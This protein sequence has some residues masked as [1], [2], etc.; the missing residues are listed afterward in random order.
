VAAAQ[1]A[2]A[3]AVRP[4]GTWIGTWAAAPQSFLPGNLE[5]FRRQTLRLIVHASVGGTTLRIKLSNAFGD[6]P[7]LIGGAHV[8]RRAADADI[9]AATDRPL[10]FGGRST[11]IVPAGSVVSSDP[12]ALDLHA[13]S[14]LAVSLYLPQTTAA[15]TSHFLAQQ[16]SYVSPD[17]GDH[18]AAAHFPVAKKI[19]QWPFLTGVDVEAPAGGAAIVAFGDST[20]DGDGSTPDANHRWPDVLAARLQTG[21]GRALGVLNQ[22]LI[23]NRLLRGSPP[24]V[25]R[26]F[27]AALGEAGVARF[28]RDVLAQAGVRYVIVRIGGNDIG[29][30][31][32]FT[33]QSQRVTAEALISGY[34][35]LIER[36][37][38]Q[39]IRIIGTTI[40]PFEN[41]ALHGYY[42]AGKELLRQRVNAWIRES[43]QFDAVIDFDRVLRDPGHPARLLPRYDSGDHLHPNDAGYAAVA[44]AV[45][46]ALFG[47]AAPR[48]PA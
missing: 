7:L 38:K 6:R 47:A 43:G 13:L 32:A 26:Q 36:A 44:N 41:A 48:A 35:Q 39:G 46:L 20:V 22:G 29:F 3:G 16:T 40:A 28:D 8:A 19:Q 5:S 45:P 42:T 17:D 15:T 27:G 12:V 37:R 1:P 14:D 9:D 24:E 33:P 34:R 10:S 18:T 2:R 23:G 4:G 11:V 31:G 21:A 30:P 25:R